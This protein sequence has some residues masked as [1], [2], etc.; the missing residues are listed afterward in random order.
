MV[1]V[2]E[3]LHAVETWEMRLDAE[4]LIMT[5]SIREFKQTTTTK[6]PRKSLHKRFNER[7]NSCA[8]A[9]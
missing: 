1:V 5:F 2:D 9:L 7:N 6:A 4:L 8:R 3:S